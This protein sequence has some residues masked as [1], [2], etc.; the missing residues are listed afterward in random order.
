MICVYSEVTRSMNDQE[1]VLLNK[2]HSNREPSVSLTCTV[3]WVSIWCACIVACGLAG[4]ALIAFAVHRVIGAILGVPLAIAAIIFLY[5]IILLIESHRNCSQQHYHFLHKKIPRI[6]KAIEVG[7][8]FVKKVSSNAVITIREFEDEGSGY[9][10][11]LGDGK[12]FFLKGQHFYPA[13]EDTPWPNSE[14]EIVRTVH[15]DIWIGIFC[16]GVELNPIRELET[17]ECIDDIALTDH[18]DV[19]DEGLEQFAKTI[20]KAE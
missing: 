10:Y 16:F 12:V 7:S 15:G 17:R 2:L 6:R 4:T 19:L 8:V 5:A 3:K 11:E 20:T 9:I 1:R 13:T 18:E 14:F